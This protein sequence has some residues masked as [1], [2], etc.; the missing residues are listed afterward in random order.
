MLSCLN[1]SPAPENYFW[2]VTWCKEVSKTAMKEVDSDISIID[3]KIE[4]LLKD[5]ASKMVVRERLQK[6]MESLDAQSTAEAEG[7]KKFMA[8]HDVKKQA[9]QERERQAQLGLKAAGAMR[10]G[11]DGLLEAMRK[12]MV[13][14]RVKAHE[15]LLDVAA[16][17]AEAYRLGHN[18]NFLLDYYEKEHQEGIK[19]ELTKETNNYKRMLFQRLTDKAQEHTAAIND[20]KAKLEVSKAKS[21]GWKTS[22]ELLES[23]VTEPWAFLCAN[24]VSGP[25]ASS[26]RRISVRTSEANRDAW[27]GG[28]RELERPEGWNEEMK[29]EADQVKAQLLL[30]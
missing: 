17:C 26:T 23:F 3:K 21:E 27:D 5:R 11:L 19:A 25:A 7:F 1:I 12:E 15:L 28:D 30:E 18:V 4:S 22:N 14:L 10:L 9:L 8:A 20:L 16:D 24:A 29:V 2:Q 13:T 6:R